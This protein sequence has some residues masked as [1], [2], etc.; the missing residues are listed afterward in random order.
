MK[1]TKES[2][3]TFVEQ[4]GQDWTTISAI[5][6][7]CGISHMTAHR[8]LN[9]LVAQWVVYKKWVVPKVRYYATIKSAWESSNIVTVFPAD[10][11]RNLHMQRYQI[12]KDW[13]E[14]VGSEWF[15]QWCKR[16]NID[17]LSAAYRWYRHTLY[18]DSITTRYGIDATKKADSYGEKVLD[19][20]WYASIYALPEFGKT[21]IWTYMEIAKV[22]PSTRIFDKIMKNTQSYFYAIIQDFGIDALCFVKPTASR[23]L[24]IMT[25]AEDILWNNLPIIPLKKKPW[26]FP[27]QKTI[28]DPKDRK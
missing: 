27:M 18:V 20:L 13:T 25:Y 21:R 9:A 8:H 26:Y 16:R 4:S 2:L 6:K 12:E 15:I 14:L 1:I 19:H 22:Q 11:Q 24:Q 10:L 17:P 7:Q 3:L 28:K 23:K 5:T